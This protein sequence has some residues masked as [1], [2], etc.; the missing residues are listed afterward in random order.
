MP[1]F[2][3]GDGSLSAGQMS[4]VS[5]APAEVEGE[6]FLERTMQP[7]AKEWR[8]RRATVAEFA[9]IAAAGAGTLYSES[10]YDSKDKAGWTG[11][12]G[13][14]EATRKALRLHS[15]QARD[16]AG[17]V[18]DGL[19]ALLIAEPIFD[20]FYTLGYR[21]RRWD[22][23]WQTSVI[24]LESLTFTSLVSSVLQISIKREKPF[25]RVCPDGSCS[26]EQ[27]NRG[28]PSGHVAFA[29]T[30]AGL[31]CTHHKYQSLYDPATEKAICVTSLGLAAVDG[32]M[33][34]MADRHY[35]TDVLAGSAIGLF[36]G[37]LLPRLLH[38]YWSDSEPEKK[39]TGKRETS[40]IRRVSLSPQIL[41]GG[42]GLSCDISF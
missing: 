35:A 24:N 11:H 20:S 21:D 33:R 28:M 40:F 23:L 13:F 38:Y 30:G 8:W 4:A 27:I 39:P 1:L 5:T 2:A 10:T 15:G 42:G 9:I 31:Y 18:G 41:S 16:A 25:Q 34:V 3:A 14:D 29:F 12:N 19:M 26:H 22:A 6:A 37:F 7:A 36:S 17:S 32:V